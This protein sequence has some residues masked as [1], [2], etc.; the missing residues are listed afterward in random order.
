MELP[1]YYTSLFDVVTVAII[2]MDKQNYGNAR[3]ILMEA[4]VKSEA[5]YIE[6]DEDDDAED[7]SEDST[8][9]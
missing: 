9:E 8:V 7:D 6:D 2:E 3:K 4:Q 5:Y 1:K